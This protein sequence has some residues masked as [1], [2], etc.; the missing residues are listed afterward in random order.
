MFDPNRG[1]SYG[2]CGFLF[3]GSE[4]CYTLARHVDADAPTTDERTRAAR[5]PTDLL[6]AI[7]NG[8]GGTDT[9]KYDPLPPSGLPFPLWIVREVRRSDGLCTGAFPWFDCATNGF[10]HETR[11]EFRYWGAFFERN[12]REFRGFRTVEESNDR[13]KKTTLYYHDAVRKGIVQ[14]VVTEP[15]SPFANPLTAQKSEDFWDCVDITN[16]SPANAPEPPTDPTQANCPLYL[17]GS[18]KRWWV[19]LVESTQSTCASAA[20]CPTTAKTTVRLN[21]A[22]DDYG[23]VTLFG[24]TETGATTPVTEA[25]DFYHFD[26]GSKYLVDKPK[27]ARSFWGSALLEYK[28]FS[29]NSSGDLIRVDS[30]LNDTT[31]G[32][33][34][35]HSC[36]QNI[37]T[38]S[39]ATAYMAYDVFGNVVASTDPAGRTTTT[40]YDPHGLFP[41]EIVNPLGQ[42]VASEYDLACG[43]LVKRSTPYLAPGPPPADWPSTTYKYDAFCRLTEVKL[44]GQ[45]FADQYIRYYLGRPGTDQQPP[46]AT[47]VRVF[48]LTHGGPYVSYNMI[49]EFRD[50]LGRSLQ[51][52]RTG[53]APN[54]GGD[55]NAVKHVVIETLQYDSEGSPVVKHAP[56]AED[57]PSPATLPAFSIP[58]SGGGQWIF[59]YDHL[60]RI[61]E[62]TAPDGS[63][64]TF[65][66]STPWRLVSYNQCNYA[67]SCSGGAMKTEELFDGSGR[68]LEKRVFQS[69][70]TLLAR[71][72]YRY[73]GLGRMISV[74]QAAT[75]TE[76]AETGSNVVRTRVTTQY[77]S[78]G[79]K[80]RV[81]DPDSGTWE[82]GYDQV[83]NLVYQNDPKTGQSMRYAYDALDR[84]TAKFVVMGDVRCTP[85]TNGCPVLRRTNYR[86]DRPPSDLLSCGPTNCP[87]GDCALGRLAAV[88]ESDPATGAPTGANWIAYCYD[89][90]GH[91]RQVRQRVTVAGVSSPPLEAEMAFSHDAQTG[92]LT[93]ITYPD[94]EIVSYSYTA[95]Y[96]TALAESSG[97][98]PKIY[99]QNL[100]YDLFGR[101]LRLEHGRAISGSDVVDQWSYYGPEGNYRLRELRTV[102]RSS[103]DE[104]LQQLTYSYQADG[105]VRT[106]A[107]GV[108]PSTD[109]R[110]NGAVFTY[111]GAGR[112]KQVAQSQ[113]N[114]TYSF[115]MLQNLKSKEGQTFTYPTSTGPHQPAS[116]AS[117][118]VAHDPNG[119]RTGWGSWQ[120]LY[121]PED[122]LTEVRQSGSTRVTMVW[123]P[124]G[125]RVAKVVGGAPTFYVGQWMEVSSRFVTKFYYVGDRLV[126]S[127]RGWGSVR[128]ELRRGEGRTPRCER[129]AALHARANRSRIPSAVA[130]GSVWSEACPSGITQL[131]G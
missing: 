59:H 115:D 86:Y 49:E 24:K 61:T 97:S 19:R 74:A 88:E 16:T 128:C 67:S 109:P 80:T 75:L 18:T 39:C 53:L 107:D 5:I 78:L 47:A 27:K 66:R 52:K 89:I 131:S 23:N 12:D 94:G 6:V 112:L 104:V 46:R 82:Y 118:T 17:S 11:T 114:G 21:Q 38:G 116:F 43:T 127:R 54:P 20:T 45:Q 10:G 120:Y 92:A 60:G 41:V 37:G 29:Y 130:V 34:A 124:A 70:N 63:K 15:K 83:G 99:V 110:Y 28:W 55:T 2:S 33:D 26:D 76:N 69:P 87:S 108:Y 113:M 35:G 106:I 25:I 42:R 96:P 65:D 81:V 77:D 68:T 79:R 36:P 103:T 22:W 71:T 73:D 93:E 122:R 32:S 57:P 72:I 101:P 95:G 56:F 9:I 14:E 121:D 44:P 123:R 105:R 13:T 126:A 40:T 1:G 4:Y 91:R 84:M 8:I 3:G 7:E 31:T 119:N 90:R 64:V 117:Q 129:P 102:R 98:A 62:Q 100:V 48:K 85:G 50:G 58:P 51:K 111:D 125:D 30:W